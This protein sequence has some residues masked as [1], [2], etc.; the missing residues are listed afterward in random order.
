MAQTKVK[1]LDVRLEPYRA[2]KTETDM[3]RYAARYPG[4]KF[5]G[6]WRRH[7]NEDCEDNLPWPEDFIDEEQS[8]CFINMVAGYL[9]SGSIRERYMGQAYCRI[10]NTWGNGSA[11]LSDGTYVWPEG[12]SHYVRE[13]K[14]RL[15]DEFVQH[16]IDRLEDDSGLSEMDI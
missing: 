16:I 8:E 6:F 13:H 14:V 7:K 12:L 1:R 4:A 15:P 5:I 9:D 2:A 3:E 10:C 11:D